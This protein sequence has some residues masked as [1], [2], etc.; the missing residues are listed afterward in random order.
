MKKTR[1]AIVAGV[2]SAMLALAG[3]AGAAP[4]AE[5][6]ASAADD[7][8]VIQ[9]NV[10]ITPIINAADVYVGI[11][12]GI[13]EEHGLDVN[14]VIVQNTST[15]IPSLLNGELQVALINSVAAVTAG[16]RASDRDDRRQRPVPG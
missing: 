10:G 2:T 3:C 6:S 14:P 13:F 15:A 4:A 16:S 5:P 1:I 12:Q 11:E 8:S 9:L 7:Q